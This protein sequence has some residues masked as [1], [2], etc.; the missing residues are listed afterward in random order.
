MAINLDPI[1]TAATKNIMPGLVDLYFKDDPVLAMLKAQRLF[2]MLGGP[3]FQENFMYAP[4]NGGFFAKGAPF[5][6]STKQ[7]YTGLTFTPRYAQVNVTEYLED[8]EVEANSPNKVLDMVQTHLGA[9]ALTMSGILAVNLYKDGQSAGR[10]LF[11]NGLSEALSDGTNA[12]YDGTTYTSYGTQTRADVSPAL[13]SPVGAQAANVAGQVTY[14]VLERS[15]MSCVIG[16]EQPKLGVTTNRGMAFIN[17]NFQPQQRIDTLEPTIGWPGIKFKAGATILTSQYAPGQDGVNDLVLGNYNL[18]TE[19][20][21]WLNP[22]PTGD[23]AYLK[24]YTSTSPKYRF[25][26]TGFK[27]AQNATK[28]AGQILWSGNFTVRAA[29]LMRI[30][31]GITS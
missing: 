22:G 15:Y 16:G 18:A 31:F 14:P 5:D 27:V 4:M 6:I 2:D 28:V 12:S 30:L 17:E 19:T 10:T 24:F 25:G 29:R 23:L 26:F 8:I 21:F 3:S 1:N 7:I 20:F 13:N 11:M 9:A